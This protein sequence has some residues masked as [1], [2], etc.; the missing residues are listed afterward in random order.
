MFMSVCADLL[1][2]RLHVHFVFMKQ[3]N[4]AAIDKCNYVQQ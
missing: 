4:I 3:G 2:P 1:I